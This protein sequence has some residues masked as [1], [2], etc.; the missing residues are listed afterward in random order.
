M[1]RIA[2]AILQY[3]WQY[4]CSFTVPYGL[5]KYQKYYIYY[6]IEITKAT[7]PELDLVTNAT[8]TDP[9]DTSAWFY[10]RWL[11]DKC[12]T[13]CSL[14]RARVKE[15][16]AVVVID[17]NM[18]VKPVSL[19]L[20]INGEAVDA[21]WHLYPEQKFAKLRVARLASPLEDLRQAKEVS[22][23]LH[24][25]TY[26]LLYS[27]SEAAWIYKDNSRLHKQN[28][29]EKQLR[30]QLENY[31]ELSRM[32]PN[33]KWVLLTKVLLMRKIDFHQFYDDI[34]NNLAALAKVDSF[35]KNYYADLRE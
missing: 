11:L 24:E 10:Q 1:Y 32:E 2:Y 8:F 33:N 26:Q 3:Y 30:E 23:K 34:L 9:N 21:Q 6:N 18:L 19:S 15:D 16:T 13:T 25:T 5:L 35:R 4:V 28:S 22:V 29:N 7:F 12:K 14:W 31:N 20:Y 17:N 27:E